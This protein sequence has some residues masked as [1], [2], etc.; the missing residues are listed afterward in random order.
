MAAGASAARSQDVPYGDPAKQERDERRKSEGLVPL[1]TLRATVTF[2]AEGIDGGPDPRDAQALALA[3]GEA[4]DTVYTYLIRQGGFEILTAELSDALPAGVQVE[5]FKIQQGSIEIVVVLVAAYRLLND[6]NQVVRTLRD[7]SESC[8][9]IL[10]T[11]LGRLTGVRVLVTGDFVAEARFD[12]AAGSGSLALLMG[13]S[14]RKVSIALGLV[15]ATIT[16]LSLLAVLVAFL[17]S[18]F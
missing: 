18:R 2:V 9:Q 7:A 6:F 15:L 14:L 13:L 8:R 16:F 12:E 10:R 5:S 11:V 3:E 4:E 17:L 1:G